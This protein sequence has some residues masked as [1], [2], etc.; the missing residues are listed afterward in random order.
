M[1][2]SNKQFYVVEII[3][4]VFLLLSQFFEIVTNCCKQIILLSI[5]FRILTNTFMGRYV[6][7]FGV[8]DML[9]YFIVS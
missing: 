9:R 2:T 6:Y 5:C 8:Y 7:E 4:D 1:G 3:L